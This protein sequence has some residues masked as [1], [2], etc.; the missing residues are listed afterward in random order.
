MSVT[1]ICI[2]K[3]VNKAGPWS[4]CPVSNPD[5]KNTIGLLIQN[6]QTPTSAR[7]QGFYALPKTH[8]EDLKIRTIVSACGGIFDRLGWLLQTILKL[9]LD[10]VPGHLK[11]T[12][13]LIKRFDAL[14]AESIKGMIAISLD[15]ISLYTNIPVD[16]AIE[17][18]WS[19]C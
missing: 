8:K 13:D 12:G 11:N 18:L 6:L 17:P 4:G 7:C 2:A 3:C 9:L 14:D 19:T 5:P 10:K 16:E 1:V 15:V